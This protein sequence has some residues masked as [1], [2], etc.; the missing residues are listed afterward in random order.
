MTLPSLRFSL[1][2][3]FFLLLV[4]VFGSDDIL[5]L[6]FFLPSC[7]F[8]SLGF[9][10]V[11]VLRKTGRPLVSKA[12]C[13]ETCREVRFPSA[14]T[15]ASLLSFYHFALPLRFA[16]CLTLWNFCMA[17]FCLLRIWEHNRYSI[18][19]VG[20]LRTQPP[21]FVFFPFPASRSS[22]VPCW[23]VW[24]CPEF[25][26][27]VSAL[28]KTLRDVRECFCSLKVL[29]AFLLQSLFFCHDWARLNVRLPAAHGI[30]FCIM[31]ASW[32]FIEDVN[33]R[34]GRSSLG[35]PFKKN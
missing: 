1:E 29:K 2:P 28:S 22:L 12:G 7:C 34:C 21:C 5:V 15:A 18:S 16:S 20:K 4:C 23:L 17:A 10:T 26:A 32:E 14:V 3:F 31:F 30:S 13:Q 8:V 19:V 24:V 11:V 33:W 6:L 25:M 9:V 27:K 35:F